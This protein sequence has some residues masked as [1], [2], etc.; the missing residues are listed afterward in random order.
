MKI[1]LSNCT[2]ICNK[3]RTKRAELEEQNYYFYA[4]FLYETGSYRQTNFVNLLFSLQNLFNEKKLTETPSCSIVLHIKMK[5]RPNEQEVHFPVYEQ[6][7]FF[8]QEKAPVHNTNFE[9]KKI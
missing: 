7:I 9:N 4:P 5:S 2:R 3:L 6:E 1:V 8:A